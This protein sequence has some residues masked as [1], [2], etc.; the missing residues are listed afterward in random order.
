MLNDNGG[1]CTLP[2]T[3]KHTPAKPALCNAFVNCV[4]NISNQVLLKQVVKIQ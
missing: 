3:H 1:M 4:C 2:P